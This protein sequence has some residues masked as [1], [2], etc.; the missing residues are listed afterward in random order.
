MLLNDRRLLWE[1]SSWVPQP[2]GLSSPVGDD[3]SALIE[4]ICRAYYNHH[5]NQRLHTE[6]AS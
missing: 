2:P 1:V 4:T 5:Y 3:A 6:R